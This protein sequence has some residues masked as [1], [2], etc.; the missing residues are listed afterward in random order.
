MRRG[1]P[2]EE[3]RPR[4]GDHTLQG[5]DTGPRAVEVHVEE[6]VLHGF[7]PGDRLGIAVA[8]E[9]ELAR[10]LARDGVPPAWHRPGERERVDGGAFRHA[11]DAPPRRTGAAVAR[12]I[13]KAVRR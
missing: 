9:R 3:T 1:G 6:L 13:W 5:P 12:E 11:P 4:A 2:P 7:A 10:L 8:V